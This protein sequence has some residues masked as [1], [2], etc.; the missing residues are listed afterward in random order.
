MND[1]SELYNVDFF[2][3][4]LNVLNRNSIMFPIVKHL[5]VIKKKIFS[6]IFYT[7]LDGRYIGGF[8]ILSQKRFSK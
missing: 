7:F 4:I 3:S 5:E 8:N 6:Q 1:S 2:N